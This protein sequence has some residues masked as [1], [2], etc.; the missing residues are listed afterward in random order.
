MNL[1]IIERPCASVPC[2]VSTEGGGR[3]AESGGISRQ[4]S[5]D[6]PV[7]FRRRWHPPFCYKWESGS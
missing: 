1:I 2:A 5:L 3:R 4:R 6:L 7:K